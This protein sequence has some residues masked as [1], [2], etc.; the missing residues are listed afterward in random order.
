MNIKI[1]IDNE[2]KISG[3]INNITS[4]DGDNDAENDYIIIIMTIIL[5]D[6]MA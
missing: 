5:Q 6:I 4:E 3:I 1:S 2:K